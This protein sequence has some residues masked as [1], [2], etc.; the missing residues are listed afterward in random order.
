[1]SGKQCRRRHAKRGPLRAGTGGW[2]RLEVFDRP[3]RKRWSI[4]GAETRPFRSATASTSI[5][6]AP[7]ERVMRMRNWSRRRMAKRPR[8]KA[9]IWAFFRNRCLGNQVVRDG[10]RV[11]HRLSAHPLGRRRL[12]C[13]LALVVVEW[14]R[15]AAVRVHHD[16]GI[17][18][19]STEGSSRRNNRLE[20]QPEGPHSRSSVYLRTPGGTVRPPQLDR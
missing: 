17:G 9:L 18:W 6:L 3:A 11:V 13:G 10:R 2:A 19:Q 4:P 20:D 8:G 14:G 15:G 5:S 1:V 12:R 7:L 16:E